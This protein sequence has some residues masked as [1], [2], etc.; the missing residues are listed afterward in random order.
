MH[1]M[2]DSSVTQLEYKAGYAQRVNSDF[3]MILWHFWISNCKYVLL[4]V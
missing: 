2:D 4:L 1:F 3:T